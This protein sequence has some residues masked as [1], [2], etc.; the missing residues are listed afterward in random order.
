MA[1]GL[2]LNRREKGLIDAYK[3][4]GKSNRAIASFLGRSHDV[5]D[6]YVRHPD[7]YGTAKH[8]R[9]PPKVT[10]RVKRSIIRGLLKCNSSVRKVATN[11][12]V[13][14]S[15]STVHR[16]TKMNGRVVYK[17]MKRSPDLKEHHKAARRLFARKNMA[18]NWN[19]MI[20]F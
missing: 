13:R 18:T 15:K 3:Q 1:C 12:V 20:S 4:S 2:K 7:T 6:R 10:K 19:K 11:L 14:A 9:R 16:V 5:I 8:P 17:K